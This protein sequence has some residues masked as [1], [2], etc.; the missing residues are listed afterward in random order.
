MGSR[1]VRTLIRSAQ[2]AWSSAPLGRR[3][4]GLFG[5]GPFARQL[6]THALSSAAD[7]CFAVSLA[8]SLFFSVSATAARPKII[9]YLLL[10]VV[11]FALAAPFIGPLVDRYRGGHRLVI[12]GVCLARGVI[13]IGM[14]GNLRTLFVY[15]EALAVLGLSK[16]YA[17]AKTALVPAIIRDAEALVDANARLSFVSALAG[18]VG[19][20]AGAAVTGLT[21]AP[22]VLVLAA[23]FYGAA[24]WAGTHLPHP[25]PGEDVSRALEYVEVHAPAPM[26]AAGAMAVL[27][28]G[29]GFLVFL[30]AFALRE[31]D[32]PAWFFGLAL[33]A[34][35]AGAVVGTFAASQLRRWL[36]EEQ[37]MALA[38]V[39]PAVFILAAGVQVGRPS[40]LGAAFSLG[41]GANVG[42]Q[43]FDSLIQHKVPDANRGRLF[44]RFE[45]GFQLAWA[46]GALVPVTLRPPTWA[47]LLAL[48]AVL[49]TGS[50][51]YVI[52]A[53]SALR[54]EAE[55]APTRL[56]VHRLIEER[57]APLDAVML[58]H[59]ADQ[60][61]RG[62]HRLAV[63]EAVAA[64]EVLL[65]RIRADQRAV[66]G[67]SIVGRTTGWWRGAGPDR[68]WMDLQ[69]MWVVAT[70]SPQ[71]LTTRDSDHAI[72]VAGRL[73]AALVVSS[74]P[75]PADQ[76]KAPVG[77]SSV[78]SGPERAG[79]TDN[80]HEHR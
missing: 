56:W 62:F 26:L 22:W 57:D 65:E 40:V 39:V 37:L 41:L 71:E 31:A 58:H 32:E 49:I 30:L 54:F 12:A 72:A 53:R 4:D 6:Q 45:S 73:M 28:A 68:D 77:R 25:G 63:V 70:S 38:L 76:V 7:A 42:R 46:L 21:G 19:A 80:R 74:G 67:R 16:M 1:A 20:V 47:G 10:T 17:V 78:G 60:A 75:R 69:Q 52:G 55:A 36:H 13:C 61:A 24:T 59:A 43:A 8:G 14:A 23:A 34:G 15:P 51:A 18:S 50:V 66:A 44:A 9:L 3:H 11:P 64:Y 27:R 35:G 48:A 2:A 5:R 29:I 33:A 79:A